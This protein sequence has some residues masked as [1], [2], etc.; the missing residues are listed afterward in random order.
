MARQAEPPEKR[1]QFIAILFLFYAENTL[2][3]FLLH[4][5]G[6]KVSGKPS[7]MKNLDNS[8]IIS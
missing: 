8:L 5:A 3:K 1:G 6:V 2:Y 7:L 4:V